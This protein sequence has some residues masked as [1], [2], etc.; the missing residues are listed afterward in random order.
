MTK[1]TRRSLIIR[2]G[3]AALLGAAGVAGC[4]NQPA[5]QPMTLDRWRA[6]RKS[7][8]LIGHRGAGG[9]L[10]EHT[11][12]S[13]L[14][15]LDRGAECL[16]ISVVL[17]SD[18]VLYCHHDL[19][20][21]RTTTGAGSTRAPAS[22]LDKVRVSVPRLGPGWRGDNSPALP[23]LEDVLK[24]TGGRAVLC[25]E[26][27]D[28]QAFD[29]MVEIVNRLELSSSVMMKINHSSARIAQ[30]KAAGFAV[31]SYLGN[32]EVATPENI[33]SAAGGLDLERDCL[34]I[35]AFN[36][37][38][39]FPAELVRVA[40]NT[41]IPIWVFPV[42]RRSEAAYF[43][44]LGVQGMIAADVGYLSGSDPSRTKDA[45]S[46]GRLQSGELTKEPYSER[47]GMDWRDSA[48]VLKAEDQPAFVCFG[49]YAPLGQPRY[50]ISFEARM[51]KPWSDSEQG[52]SI[53]FCRDD[54]SYYA[55]RQGK[56]DGYHGLLRRSGSI[57]LFA[58]RDGS[59]DGRPLADALAGE[60]MSDHWT[61]LSVEVD[62][63][64]VRFGQPGKM[65]TAPDPSFRGGYFHIG[66]TSDD[67]EL[68]LRNLEVNR[69]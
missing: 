68:E 52:V 6:R 9:V 35:P 56:G 44:Y 2:A 38:G 13:Y 33:R 15:A 65:V 25:I 66:R 49:G 30:A 54:D 22:V 19:S 62:P 43:S 69:L 37:K 18:G 59:P 48:L 41:K 64:A 4:A 63:G 23:R 26:A 20:L 57:E 67:G 17:S 58:H 42:H 50:R 29:P 53:A 24:K 11:L 55:H 40:V 31:F 45:W 3:S 7:P 27:K 12:E 61:K 28:D 8:Y 16:E 60:P 32:A 36:E 10:P 5:T 14:G 39:M 51:A 21:D 1:V 47:F 46:Q 34:V